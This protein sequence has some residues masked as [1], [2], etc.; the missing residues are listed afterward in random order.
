MSDLYEEIGLEVEGGDT[1]VEK[2]SA[3]PTKSNSPKTKVVVKKKGGGWLGRIVALLLGMVIGVG[4]CVGGVYLVLSQPVEKAVNL[5]GGFAGIDYETTVKDKYLAAEYGDKTLLEVGKAVLGAAAQQNLQGIAD[6]S[7]IVSEVVGKMV[8]KFNSG[9][10]IQMNAEELMVTQFTELPTFLASTFRDAPIGSMLKATSGKAQLEPILMEICYGE[11]NVH[12]VFDENGEVQMINGAKA[13]TFET[14]GG[15]PEELIN[16]VSLASV[17]TPDPEDTVM[18]AL[19]YGMEGTTFEL[20]T[21]EDGNYVY[22]TNG[23]VVV[24]MLPL[25]YTKDESGNFFDHTDKAV[26]GTVTGEQDGYIVFEKSPEYEGAIPETYYLKD[27]NGDGN[28]Y[29]FKAP[30]ED[31]DPVLFKKTMIGDMSQDSM[32]IIDNIYL[33]DALDINYKEGTASPH[34]I[35]F[36]LAYGTEGMDYYV[37]EA[38]GK[39]IVMIGNAKPRTIGELRQK[40]T[41]LINDISLSDIMTADPDDAVNMYLLYGRENVHYRVETDGS[42]TMLTKRIAIQDLSGTPS[43]YNEYG[44]PYNSASIALD[45]ANAKFTDT[46]GTV[47]D[48]VKATDLEPMKIGEGTADIYYLYANGNPV[49]YE[50][51]SLGDLTGSDNV[52]TRMT[53]RLTANEVFGE[54]E[55]AHNKF[56]KY[57]GDCT[58]EGLSNAVLDLTIAQVFHADIYQADESVYINMSDSAIL[59]SNGATIEIG[60]YYR[61]DEDNNKYLYVPT[62]DDVLIYVGDVSFLDDSAEQHKICAGDFFKVSDDKRYYYEPTGEDVKSKW[63]YLLRTKDEHGNA[64]YEEALNYKASQD[65]DKLLNNMTTNVHDATLNELSQDEILKLDAN[66]LNSKVEDK[67]LTVNLALPEGVTAGMKL[68]ELTTEQMLAY[69]SVLMAAIENI[70]NN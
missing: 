9:F 54:S 39:N 22:D 66:M 49:K 47:Y 29:A 17:V 48:Y 50:K 1:P 32:S 68:G 21:D 18:L 62:A 31:A 36:S 26:V 11:E 42:I 14:L 4:G 44:E 60:G 25:F 20:E 61:M 43:I 30:A 64:T 28:Y 3:Q 41:D 34:K 38:N 35:L 37:D 15:S 5:I 13:A 53:S 55:V 23:H 45:T 56:L 65:M 58:I 16:K 69:T 10:G 24:N 52:I 19:A 8:D 59:D 51:T 7:P 2:P 33:K 63:K 67:I 70:N 40:N 27:V 46:D 12:Y 57:V 6:I